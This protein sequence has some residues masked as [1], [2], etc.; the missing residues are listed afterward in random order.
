M[1]VYGSNAP[2]NFH[3]AFFLYMPGPGRAIRGGAGQ[4]H[5]KNNIILVSDMSES[6]KG[7]VPKLSKRRESFNT[8]HLGLSK[9]WERF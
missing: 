4:T 3:G 8:L 5:Y 7:H 2:R 6:S 9:R 1:L